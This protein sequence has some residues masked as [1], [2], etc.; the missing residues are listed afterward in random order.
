MFR[1][2]DAAYA[3]FAIAAILSFCLRRY[4]CRALLI[5][6]VMP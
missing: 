6:D 1:A 2:A 5:I 4:A 3:D